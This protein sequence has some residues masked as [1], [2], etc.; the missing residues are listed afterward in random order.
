MGDI[1]SKLVIN[2]DMCYRCLID[3]QTY[4]NM[5]HIHNKMDYLEIIGYSVFNEIAKVKE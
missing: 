1:L 4:Y 5:L 2:I 3:S